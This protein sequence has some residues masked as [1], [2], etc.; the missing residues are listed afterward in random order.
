MSNFWRA[1]GYLLM[2]CA[3]GEIILCLGQDIKV[4]NRAEDDLS[5]ISI[6]VDSGFRRSFL[7]VRISSALSCVPAAPFIWRWSV[8]PVVGLF[9]GAAGFLLFSAST[10]CSAAGFAKPARSSRSEKLTFLSV[11]SCDRPRPDE[12]REAVS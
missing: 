7:A 8:A 3:V 4:C 9:F 5:S 10:R 1:F 6:L 12:T 2:A 11:R